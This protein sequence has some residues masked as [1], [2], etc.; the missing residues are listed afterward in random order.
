[1]IYTE[2]YLKNCDEETIVDLYN[3]Q[4]DEDKKIPNIDMI[5]EEGNIVYMIYCYGNSTKYLCRVFYDPNS[6]FNI[7]ELYEPLNY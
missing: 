3:N 4:Y 2:E 6:N 5:K 1:M 7:E